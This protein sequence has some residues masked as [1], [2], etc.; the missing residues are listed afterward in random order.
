LAA[1]QSKELPLALAANEQA[2]AL[3]PESIDARYNFALTLRDARYYT[4]AANEL[5]Q[6]LSQAPNEV[7]ARLALANVYAQDLDEPALAR[8][9]YEKVLELSPNHPQAPFIRQWIATSP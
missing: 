9:Q 3:K 2:V 8:R 7:R 5:Q 6:L 1:Y 4:D